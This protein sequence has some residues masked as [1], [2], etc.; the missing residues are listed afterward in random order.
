[1]TEVGRS[2]HHEF[3]LEL[4]KAFKFLSNLIFELFNEFW[5]RLRTSGTQQSSKGGSKMDH[6]QAWTH[7]EQATQN[8]GEDSRG[9]FS[10]C[11]DV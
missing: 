8:T 1:M 2:I 7:T 11:A 3:V 10:S 4:S 5:C 9:T 6:H